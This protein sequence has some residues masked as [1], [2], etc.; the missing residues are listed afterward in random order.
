VNHPANHIVKVRLKQKDQVDLNNCAIYERTHQ[1]E[2]KF[3]HAYV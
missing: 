3:T 1:D 2:D